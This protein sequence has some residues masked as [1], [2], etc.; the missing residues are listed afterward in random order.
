MLLQ[1]LLLAAPVASANPVLDWNAVMLGAIRMETTAPTLATRNLAILN[2]SMHDAVQAVAGT[3]QPYR[4]QPVP[5]PETSQEAAAVGAGYEVLKVLYPSARAR[6]DEAFQMWQSRVTDP[7]G[8]TE[9]LTLGAEVARQMIESRASDGSQTQVPYIPSDAP[10]AWRRTQPFFRPPLD[11][12]WRYVQPFA[13]P[14]LTHFLPSPPPPLESVEYAQAWDDVRRF[15]AKTGSER[16]AEQSQIAVFWSDFSYT[17]TP[18]GHWLEMATAI[19]REKE[20]AL[21]D[22][23][24]L[25]ALL[26]IAQADAAIVCW[27]AKYRHNFWRPVTAIQQAHRD[28]NDGT[29]VDAAWDHYL[30]SPPFPS[31]TSGHSTFSQA[32]ADIL[33]AFYGTDAITFTARSDS[34]PGVVRTYHSLAQ[35]AAEIGRSR[36]YGG[37]HFEF[38]SNEGLSSGARIARFIAQHC[39]IP[40]TFLPQLAIEHGSPLGLHMRLHGWP[41]RSLILEASSDLQH[42]QAI[43]THTGILGGVPVLATPGPEG[44]AFFR[45]QSAA[46]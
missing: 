26:A 32:S 23:A 18:P 17:A 20:T 37:I 39:L 14:D 46:P 35:C 24:R 40:T 42:W 6:A 38:D 29:T 4:F 22:C 43:S 13:L 34:L 41:Q 30:A 15:G 33:T 44:Y 25:F 21:D 8:V 31:Y 5:A 45:L 7:T 11:P 1:V 9:G 28:G 19:A 3:C 12:H 16:T 27:E 2:L 10:G 36:I